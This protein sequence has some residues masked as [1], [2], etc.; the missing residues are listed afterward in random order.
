ME[1]QRLKFLQSYRNLVSLFLLIVANLLAAW[2][3]LSLGQR[4]ENAHVSMKNLLVIVFA[5]IAA[6]SFGRSFVLFQVNQRRSFLFSF[7]MGTCLLG[8]VLKAWSLYCQGCAD[9]G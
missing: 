6:I 9:S 7:S 5:F 2:I 8:W 1:R 3:V 4:A